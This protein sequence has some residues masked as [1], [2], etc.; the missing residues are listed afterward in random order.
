MFMILLKYLFSL[1]SIYLGV[2]LLDHISIFTF[3]NFFIV[4]KCIQHKIY[5]FNFFWWGDSAGDQIQGLTYD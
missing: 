4:V 3:F 1:L 5:L 2:E